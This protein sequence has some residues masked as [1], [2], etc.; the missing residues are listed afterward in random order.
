MRIGL[1][2]FCGLLMLGMGSV[3]C[4]SSSDPKQPAARGAATCPTATAAEGECDAA[5]EPVKTY[6][7]QLAPDGKTDA[8]YPGTAVSRL[9]AILARVRAVPQATLDG[10]WNACREALLT[11]GGLR[12]TRQTSHAFND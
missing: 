5:S 6:P 2:G 3:N 4:S 8:A 10:P 9:V 11:A 12:A 1:F 7:F